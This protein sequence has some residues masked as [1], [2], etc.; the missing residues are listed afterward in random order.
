[1]TNSRRPRLEKPCSKRSRPIKPHSLPTESCLPFRPAI[2]SDT[3]CN[4]CRSEERCRFEPASCAGVTKFDVRQLENSPHRLL[5]G[6]PPWS[7]SDRRFL[8]RITKLA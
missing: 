8:R 1:V 6:G 7:P 2:V 5:V 4:H 3:T